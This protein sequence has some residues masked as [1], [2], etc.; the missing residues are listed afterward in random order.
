MVIPGSK[1]VIKRVIAVEF[2][3]SFKTRRRHGL[4]TQSPFGLVEQLVNSWKFFP[5]RARS[6][7]LLRGHVTAHNEAD[8][9]QNQ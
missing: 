5:D 6:H 1:Q 2:V 7:S 4:L 3:Y 9:G 8:S